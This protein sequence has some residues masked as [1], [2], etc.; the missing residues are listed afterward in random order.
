MSYNQYICGREGVY[1]NYPISFSNSFLLLLLKGFKKV[2]QKEKEK[3]YNFDLK[4]NFSL[5]L[6]RCERVMP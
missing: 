5:F 1:G 4:L 3:S 6:T 2:M